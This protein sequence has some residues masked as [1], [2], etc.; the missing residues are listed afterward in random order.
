MALSRAA[1]DQDSGHVP[2]DDQLAFLGRN[3]AGR[4]LYGGRGS[5]PIAM[6]PIYGRRW[7]PPN[8]PHDL[9]LVGLSGRPQPLGDAAFDITCLAHVHGLPAAVRQAGNQC[10]RTHLN[11]MSPGGSSPGHF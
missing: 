4:I 8:S 5:I 6:A 10:R 11:P 3:A 9:P 1:V 7:P 2:G